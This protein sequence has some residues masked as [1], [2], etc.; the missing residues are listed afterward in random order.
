MRIFRAFVKDGKRKPPATYAGGIF[1]YTRTNIYKTWQKYLIAYPYIYNTR[2]EYNLSTR[3]HKKHKINMK[4]NN[5]IPC[6]FF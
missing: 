1:Y 6:E 4:Q 5:Q 2:G 3:P